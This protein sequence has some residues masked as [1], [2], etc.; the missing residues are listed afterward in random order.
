MRL[1]ADDATAEDKR[2]FEQWLNA[3]LQD[4]EQ[5]ILHGFVRSSVTKIPILTLI[6]PLI[7]IATGLGAPTTLLA[8][9]RTRVGE[10]TIPSARRY[11]AR[12][13]IPNPCRKLPYALRIHVNS[14]VPFP[15]SSVYL[16]RSS[17]NSESGLLDQSL[18]SPALIRVD[19]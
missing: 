8:D 11:P 2:A 12:A 1:D 19:R 5:K 16:Q 3:H 17:K 9:H 6:V 10:R 7:W 18:Q 13:A 15:R 4:E 14:T